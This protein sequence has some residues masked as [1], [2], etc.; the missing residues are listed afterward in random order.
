[1]DFKQEAIVVLKLMVIE[2]NKPMQLVL[3]HHLS[4]KYQVTIFP[5]GFEAMSY[6]HAGNVVDMI[7]CDLN[8]PRMNGY[9][10]LDQLRTSGFFSSIPILILSGEESTETRIKCLEAGADDYVLK[11]FNP[12]ELLARIHAILRRTGKISI[13]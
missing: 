5:D 1:V 7:I 8:T 2:D 6:L 10:L 4:A 13:I 12:K 11:P 9:E 3:N